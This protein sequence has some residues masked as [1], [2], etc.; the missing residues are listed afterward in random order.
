MPSSILQK[1]RNVGRLTHIVNILAR[2]GFK[3][4]IQRTE[5]G[6]LLQSTNSENSSQEQSPNYHFSRAKRLAMAFEEL[7]PTFVKLAQLLSAREDLLPKSYVEEFK[8]LCDK[9]KPINKEIIEKT[10]ENELPAH[11][12]EEIEF[13]DFNPIGSASIGQVHKALLKGGS[14]VVFKIQRPDID[15]AI[16]ND[17]AILMTIA[18]ILETALPEL[19][20]LRPT[21]IVAELRRSLLNELDYSREA[22]NTERMRQFFKNHENIHIPVINYKFCTSKILCM[23]E[24]TGKKFTESNIIDGGHN[25]VKIAVEAFLDMT[26]QFGIFHGDLHPGNLIKMDD[27]KLGILDFGLTVRLKRDLRNTLAFM[28]YS[29]SKHDIETCARL[30]VELT[31]KDDLTLSSQLESEISEILDNI[32][33]LPI[34]DLHLGRTLMRIARI[35]ANRNAPL[36]R[37]LILF[38]RALIALETFGRSVDPKF[39]ILNFAT[40]YYEKNSLFQFDKK[41]FERNIG[42]A[43]HDSGAFIKDLPITLRIL[44]KKLQSGTL[45]FQFKSEDIIFLT[46]ELDRASNRL[47]LA[48]LLGSIV[49]GS[50]IATYG[51]QGKLYDFLAT[52]GLIGFGTAVILGLWLIIGIIRSGRFK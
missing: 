12:L 6:D 8:R 11:L 13:F 3:R 31:E 35:S 15:I 51:K 30:F 29:L 28:F 9:V 46:R 40:E 52:F 47:S 7:G 14:S 50:S 16:N 36:E 17:L 43:M 42:L 21:I 48:I 2:Y 4:E 33:S 5:L 44:A 22:A 25:L 38:F 34:Q 10:L 1:F 27:G 32:I 20:L 18:S 37:D 39:Q 45:A 26:F 49:L 41:W 23:S 24:V 19:K